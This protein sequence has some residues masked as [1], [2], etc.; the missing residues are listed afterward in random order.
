MMTCGCYDTAI[1]VVCMM[2]T[3]MTKTAMNA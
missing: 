1:P 2:T 3:M